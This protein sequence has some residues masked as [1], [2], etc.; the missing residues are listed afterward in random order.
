[1]GHDAGTSCPACAVELLVRPQGPGA[2]EPY[3]VRARAAVLTVPL[4][5]LSA[6]VAGGEPRDDETG[7]CPAGAAGGSCAGN[8]A[9]SEQ[10]L[11]RFDPEM[12]A[13]LAKT[14]A[15]VG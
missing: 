13:E 6:S 7:Q 11:V 5:V 4:G 2:S 12:P 3:W 14:W 10:G 8:L 9:E 15:K 1:M